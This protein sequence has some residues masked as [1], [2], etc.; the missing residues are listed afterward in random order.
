MA[1]VPMP[2]I[3]KTGSAS[4]DKLGHTSLDRHGRNPHKQVRGNF[5]PT[6]EKSGK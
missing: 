6:D 3:G 5:T 2:S 4:I 1:N